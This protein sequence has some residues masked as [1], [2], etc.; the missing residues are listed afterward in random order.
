ME[1]NGPTSGTP[2]HMGVLLFS[3][4]PVALDSV[5]A[6]LVALSPAL[7][8]T[9]AAGEAQGLGVMEPARIRVVTPEG[10]LSVAQAAAQYGNPGFDVFR[11]TLKKGLAAKLLPLLPC[12]QDR[13]RVDTAKCI[14]CGLCQQSCPVE[15]KA[16]KAGN[17]Q[18]AK[19]D[20]A[21]CIRCFCCQEMCPAKAISVHRS[22][23]NHLLGGK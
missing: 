3:D 13:P 14:G 23:L 2:V 10:P 7:V 15:S 21:K 17:G 9:C 19:Y 12:L 20:Y 8:P 18:K 4:D 6:S 5:F 11:G 1:G 22:W 16:V